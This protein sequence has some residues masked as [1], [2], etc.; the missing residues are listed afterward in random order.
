M[1]EKILLLIFLTIPVKMMMTGLNLGESLL[2]LGF[3][4]VLTYMR[5]LTLNKEKPV[6]N[7]VHKELDDLK[8][9]V[10]KLTL[11]VAMRR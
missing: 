6:N 7:A 5:Y 9:K 11:Q 4:G 10:E 3:L 8:T 2:G 1:L